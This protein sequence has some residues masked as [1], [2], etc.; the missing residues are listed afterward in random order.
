MNK[1]VRD[2][3][4]TEDDVFQA[5]K[6]YW[7]VAHLYEPD[8]NFY[9]TNDDGSYKGTVI[10]NGQALPLGTNDIINAS[11]E[12][13]VLRYYGINGAHLWIVCSAI[14]TEPS[15]TITPGDVNGDNAVD[16]KDLTALAR[17]VAKI[18]LITD[19]T[20]LKNADVDGKNGITAADLTKLARYVAKI[21]SEL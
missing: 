9:A 18:E 17:H 7:Y 14:P 2:V 5:G 11:A 1:N 15:G 10:V 19:E 16:A 12:N 13:G 4:P 20:L 8:G 3:P 6:T 21:I